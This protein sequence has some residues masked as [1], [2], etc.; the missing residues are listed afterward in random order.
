MAIP[1][2]QMDSPADGLPVGRTRETGVVSR[3]AIVNFY[4]ATM[5]RP[6][7]KM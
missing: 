4:H 6:G 5:A 1:R 2:M 7:M 3:R